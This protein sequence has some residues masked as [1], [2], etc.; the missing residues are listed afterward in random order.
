LRELAVAKKKKIVAPTAHW[1]G[2]KPPKLKPDQI[3][4]HVA[5]VMDMAA[6]LKSGECRELQDMK[7]VRHLY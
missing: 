6:G 5:V 7:P 1:T 3:P 2:A 4:N